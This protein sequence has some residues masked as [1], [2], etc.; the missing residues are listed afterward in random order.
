MSCGSRTKASRVAKGKANHQTMPSLAEQFL[1]LERLRE[2]VRKAELRNERR[3]DRRR[4]R[5][6][7]D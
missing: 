1:E 5:I 7:Q 3:R 2:E 4:R 6:I